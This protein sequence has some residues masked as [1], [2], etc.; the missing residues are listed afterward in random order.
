MDVSKDLM[1]RTG[2]M[3]SILVYFLGVA[4]GKK[5]ILSVYMGDM[6]Q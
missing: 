5:S 6:I 1:T 3:M 2:T 4:R